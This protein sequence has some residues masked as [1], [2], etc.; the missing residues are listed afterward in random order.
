MTSSSD[1]VDLRVAL[2]LKINVLVAVTKKKMFV[3]IVIVPV[4]PSG[5]SIF[6]RRVPSCFP[7]LRFLRF[8]FLYAPKTRNYT[9]LRKWN[10]R[11]SNLP[12][13]VHVFLL[14]T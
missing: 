9:N 3:T 5:D 14:Y 11:S 8:S 2:S 10:L 1:L 6:F 12:V 4:L 7:G 13:L